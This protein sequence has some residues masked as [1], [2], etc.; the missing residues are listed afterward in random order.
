MNELNRFRERTGLLVSV[1]DAAEALVALDGGA[2]V[3][4]VKEPNRGSLG[5]ADTDAIAAVVAAVAGR[6]PISVAAGELLD[7]P[8]NMSPQFVDAVDGRAAFV[9]LGLAGC[10]A[11]TDWQARWR[12]AFDA[13][14]DRVQSVAVVYADWQAARAPTPDET[15]AH[16]QQCGCRVIL[17][18]TWNKSFGDL[19][20]CWTAENLAEFA[21][22]VRAAGIHLVLAGSL[23]PLTLAKAVSLRPALVAVRGAVCE[24]DRGGTVS[25]SRVEA[26]RAALDDAQ[27]PFVKGVTNFAGA[28]A[29]IGSVIQ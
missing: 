26:V 22:R 5:A 6:A 19:F 2:D 10:S 16:A 21:H 28:R 17:V 25:R 13:L 18:D 7:W 3:I 20:G 29:P 14:D 9:K 24:G 12:E 15:L 4:D 27:L 8:T 23:K 11:E 1:R